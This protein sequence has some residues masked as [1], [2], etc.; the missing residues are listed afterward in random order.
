M[1]YHPFIPVKSIAT[2]V[3]YSI[4]FKLVLIIYHHLMKS[5]ISS[6]VQ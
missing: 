1:Y 3:K 4:K 5:L 6:V 2:N